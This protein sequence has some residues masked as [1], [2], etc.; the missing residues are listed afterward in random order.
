MGMDTKLNWGRLYEQGR[1][2]AIGVPWTNEELMA[3][4]S[5][6][7]AKYVRLGILS[8]AE[9]EA[10]KKKDDAMKETPLI[11]QTKDELLMVAHKK[12]IPATHD[13]DVETIVRLIESKGKA[14]KPAPEAPEPKGKTKEEVIAEK[15]KPVEP[16]ESKKP[17]KKGEKKD[18]K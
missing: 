7:P 4:Q 1:C 18:A 14:E 15:P 2:K 13:A 17:A 5:G 3:W 8:I 9:Y 12:G 10:R 6:I 11:H 16:A